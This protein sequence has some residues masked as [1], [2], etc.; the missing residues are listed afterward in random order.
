MERLARKEDA[1]AQMKKIPLGRWGERREIADATVWLFSTAGGYV[2]GEVL[3]GEFGFF[4]RSWVVG[5][6]LRW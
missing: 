1:D 3:V 2:N 6:S 5:G 4:F